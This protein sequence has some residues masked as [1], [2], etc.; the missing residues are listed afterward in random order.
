MSIRMH[1]WKN[2]FVVMLSIKLVSFFIEL[3][4]FDSYS[5]SFNLIFNSNNNHHSLMCILTWNLLKGIVITRFNVHYL[6]FARF[7]HICMLM[8]FHSVVLLIQHLFVECLIWRMRFSI[9]LSFPH[10]TTHYSQRLNSKWYSI[11]SK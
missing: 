9:W 6:P 1:H 3:F 10:S 5:E 2:G 11:Q 8:W 7:C 4:H